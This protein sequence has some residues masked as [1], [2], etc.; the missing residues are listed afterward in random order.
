M[1]LG[2]RVG[3]YK[4]L[5]KLGEGGMGEVYRAVDTEL[6]REVAVKILPAA[7][8]LDS[9]RLGRFQREAELLASLNHSHIAVLYGVEVAD[10]ARAIVMELVSGSDLSDRIAKGPIPVSQALPIGRQIAEALSI[11]LLKLPSRSAKRLKPRT[12]RASSTV[13]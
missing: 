5:A 6:K 11:K 1:L 8:A 10:N 2:E 3:R 9:D 4:I 7:F 13:T 12:K